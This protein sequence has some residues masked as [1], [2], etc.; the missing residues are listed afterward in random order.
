M[1]PLGDAYDLVRNPYEMV[2]SV[3]NDAAARSLAS[4]AS[5]GLVERDLHTKSKENE[6][7][8]L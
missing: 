5:C 7:L 2:H 3:V 4:V 8:S 1:V 6:H